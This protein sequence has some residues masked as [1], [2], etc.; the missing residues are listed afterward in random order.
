MSLAYV[1][2]CMGRLEH[3][4]RSLPRIVGQPGVSCVVVDY[5]CPDGAGDWVERHHHGVKVVRIPGET[6]FNLSR[7]RNAGAAAAGGAEWLGFF[8]ADILLDESFASKVVPSLRRGAYYRS[9]AATLQTWGS[10]ICHRDDF[11]AIG[12][13]DENY[14]GWGG[15]DDDLVWRFT[16]RGSAASTFPGE[17]VEAIDHSDEMRTRF[18]E[19]KDWRVQ[20][21]INTLYRTVKFDLTA[22]AGR[23][24]QPEVLR[25]VFQQITSLVR[26]AS[27]PAAPI[28][29]E[30]DLGMVLERHPRDSH[31]QTINRKLSYLAQTKPVA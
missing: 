23:P 11:H 28:A 16:A 3:L 6:R 26:A 25:A 8:D 15:E 2:T 9:S 27:D 19:V 13:Y 7:A 20:L 4:Q 21:R 24:V 10:I 30:L 29:L 12:G 5:S 31:L 14:E 18:H 22:L 17:L 1:T